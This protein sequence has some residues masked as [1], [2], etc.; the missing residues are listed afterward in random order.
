MII[1]IKDLLSVVVINVVIAQITMSALNVIKKLAPNTEKGTMSF[2]F[3]NVPWYHTSEA[4]LPALYPETVIV[5]R[6]DL[7][8]EWLEKIKT[9]GNV[10]AD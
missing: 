4:L 10:R 8:R 6:A 5:T 7:D 2:S 9:Y 3:L 1:V